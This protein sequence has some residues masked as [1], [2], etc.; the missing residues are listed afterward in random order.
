MTRRFLR[1]SRKLVFRLSQYR[2]AGRNNSSTISPLT[3]TLPKTWDQSQQRAEQDE[4]NR[5]THAVA[6]AEDRTQDDGA[7]QRDDDLKPKHQPIL[8]YARPL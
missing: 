4:Q 7:D 5:G 8:P 6:P 2:I 3:R 1:I